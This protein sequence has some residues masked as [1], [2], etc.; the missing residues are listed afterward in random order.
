M[1]CL[2]QTVSNCTSCTSSAYS[3]TCK[4]EGQEVC[5]HRDLL[6]DA[7]PQCDQVGSE[8]LGIIGIFHILSFTQGEDEKGC[9]QEYL[10]KKLFPEGA[11]YK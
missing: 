11:L 5:I 10:D 3:V 4:K 8:C 6:C 9:T 7:T 1:T 2:S